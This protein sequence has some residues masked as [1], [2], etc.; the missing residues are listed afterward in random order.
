[1]EKTKRT[2]QIV[3]ALLSTYHEDFIQVSESL[4]SITLIFDQRLHNKVR[5]ALA[6]AEALVEGRESATITVQSPREIITTSGCVSSLYNQLSRR[7]VNLEDTV[8]C[9]IDTIMVVDMKDASGAF[10]ALTELVSKE[11]RRL[12]EYAGQRTA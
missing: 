12:G 4:S 5:K 8:R 11:Q 1:V 2:L 3:S 10:E 6:G 9:Y 7:K